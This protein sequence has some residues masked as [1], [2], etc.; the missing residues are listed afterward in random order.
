MNRVKVRY[1]NTLQNNT[2]TN[3]L[4]EI[5]IYSFNEPSLSKYK[6]KH[7]FG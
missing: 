4:L 2:S 3:K 1:L 7:I 5:I 6:F